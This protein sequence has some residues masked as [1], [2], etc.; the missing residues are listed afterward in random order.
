MSRAFSTLGKRR[1][2]ELIARVPAPEQAAPARA[3]EWDQPRR[4]EQEAPELHTWLRRYAGQSMH[5]LE[6]AAD[7][8]ETAIEDGSGFADRDVLEYA[9]ICLRSDR[10]RA[11]PTTTPE[12]AF[13]MS[14]NGRRHWRIKDICEQYDISRP[15]LDAWRKMDGFPAPIVDS[16]PVWDAAAVEDWRD[17]L[18]EQERGRKRQA[19]EI[20]RTGDLEAAA[21][22]ASVSTRTIRRWLEAAAREESA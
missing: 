5:Y 16:P 6:Q 2:A 17:G 13:S 20:A 9:Y 21:R 22:S 8:L 12:E 18:L 11:A 4:W 3:V 7:E 1:R 19:L 14:D 10:R 15:T